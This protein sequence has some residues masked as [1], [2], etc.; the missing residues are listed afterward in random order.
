[1]SRDINVRSTGTHGR[2]ETYFDREITRKQYNIAM[3]NGGR[4]PRN[5]ENRILSDSE[6]FG[7]GSS[8]STVFEQDGI[9][10]VHCHRYNSCD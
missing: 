7:Y 1:M 9:Y 10:Y 8:C 6:R 4:M 3:E 5:E 2:G